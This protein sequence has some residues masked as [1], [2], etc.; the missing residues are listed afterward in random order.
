MTAS[1]G[2]RPV[3][4][5]SSPGALGHL[6][7]DFERD[8]LAIDQCR[9]H[10]GAHYTSRAVA[11]AWLDA[12]RRTSVASAMARE[13]IDLHIHVGG[14]V[15]PHILWSIAHQQG[16]KLPV[17][18]YFEFVELITARP[19][20]VGSLEDYLK[21]MHTWTE[22]IQTSPMAIE[23]SRLRGDRQ[24]VPRQPGDA[25]RAA[26]QPDEAQPQLRAGPGPHH[27]RGAARHGP[28]DARVR[29]EG[30][31]HLLPGPRVRPPAQRDHRGEGD[32]VPPPRRGG[33]RPRRHR[34]ERAGARAR[35]GA[36]STRT[37]SSGRARPGSRPPCTPA[38]PRAPAPRA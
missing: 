22:K 10:G 35:G 19:G 2:T 26:L 18:N 9:C 20:K 33:H 7:P 25:D 27:P 37:S 16:F 11:E 5:L 28:G 15:A 4:S 24:G 21:I 34:E 29:R 1:P 8:G 14:A 17:K 31:P 36:R 38:R 32:Q 3:F 13:L 12:G 30:R 6:L 23:R